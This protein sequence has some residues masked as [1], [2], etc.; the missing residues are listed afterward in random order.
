MATNIL[1]LG[2]SFVALKNA[3]CEMCLLD[4]CSYTEKTER[5]SHATI[6]DGFRETTSYVFRHGH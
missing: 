3:L 1:W 6:V 2:C 5:F 4:R